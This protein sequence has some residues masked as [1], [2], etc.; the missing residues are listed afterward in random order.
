VANPI[1]VTNT[2]PVIAL[3]AAGELQL[4]DELFER[5]C[6]PMEVWSELADK[7]GALEPDQLR[8]LRGVAFFPAQPVPAEAARLDP[9][10]RAVIALARSIPGAWVLLDEL[11][12]RRVAS[13]LGLPVKGTLGV[14][15]EAKRRGLVPAVRPLVERMIASGFHLGPDLVKTLLSS[16]GE[17]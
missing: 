13:E 5:I 12:A 9:G 2:S 11:A 14:L 3:V 7:H 16:V 15:V 1:A 10:E 4:L 8:A 17:A 6:V